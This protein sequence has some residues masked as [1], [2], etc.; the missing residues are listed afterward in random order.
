MSS[1]T[2]EIAK[3]EE[4]GIR[5][6]AEMDQTAQNPLN[7]DE[8]VIFA[9]LHR[10]Y[11]N[12]AEDHLN[13]VDAI[14]EFE[15]ENT[16]DDSEW[17]VFPLWMFDHSGNVYRAGA[18]NPFSCPWDSGR[19][20]VIALKRSEFGAPAGETFDA[21]DCANAICANYTDWANGNAWGYVVEDA[22]GVSLDSCWGYVGDHDEEYFRGEA[23]SSFNYH[24]AEARKVIGEAIVESRPDMHA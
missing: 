9:V 21:L 7:D 16:G 17:M 23:M 13:S 14:A 18:S 20:G 6:F 5:V 3:D 22:K 1:E 19:V 15:A 2:V 24:V 11:D 4:T 10:H 8:A 12:P